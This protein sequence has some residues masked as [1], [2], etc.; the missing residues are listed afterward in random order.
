MQ[1]V[2]YRLYTVGRAGRAEGGPLF[3]AV[4][5]ERG[6]LII[7][8]CPPA[9]AHSQPRPSLPLHHHLS[10]PP[11]FLQP[12]FSP[13]CCPPLPPTTSPSTPH[14]WRHTAPSTVSRSLVCFFSRS[15]PFLPRS[16]PSNPHLSPAPVNRRPSA[17]FS[18]VSPPHQLSTTPTK[19]SRSLHLMARPE[20]PRRSPTPTAKSSGTARSV[21]FS[22]PNS[23][24]AKPKTRTLL[25]RRCCRTS[26]SRSVR[27]HS[28]RC[29]LCLR[30]IA[31]RVESRAADHETGFPSQCC[32]PQSFFLL[33]RRQGMCRPVLWFRH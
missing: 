7:A 5:S 25:L 16:R 24:Q 26:D 3:G 31:C 27:H 11:P 2:R 13:R 19:S 8:L 1:R 29:P 12:S 21:L 23:S 33:Q 20:R 30:L 17:P 4:V 32:R 6:H 28:L 18:R 22:R 14:P 9:S 10:L 15:S